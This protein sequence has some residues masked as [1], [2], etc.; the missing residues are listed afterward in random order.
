VEKNDIVVDIGSSVGPFAYKAL[1]NNIKKIYCIE[2]SKSL[3]QT[4]V[5]NLSKFF[6]DAVEN[7]IT[8][9]NSAI[10]DENSQGL[11]DSS[12]HQIDVYGNSKECK[13]ITFGNFL[14]KYKINKINFLKIDC[15]GGEYSI[16]N[17]KYFDYI[18]TNVEF[19]ACEVHVRFIK[20]G[21][22]KFLNLRDNFLSNF[23]RENYKFM[24]NVDDVYSD[25][26]DSIFT[27]DGCE[28]I[29]NNTEIMLYINNKLN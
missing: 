2:P 24:C 11:V 18:K 23:S 10:S 13:M 15:E 20:N 3:I 27:Y 7:P 12:E 14:E 17:E 9:I 19:I 5:K 6:I 26:S 25:V 8:F 28:Y 16:L 22:E 21:M 4:N 29:L 1:S